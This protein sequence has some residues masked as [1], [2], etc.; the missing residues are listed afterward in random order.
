[1]EQETLPQNK[2]ELKELIIKIVEEI[3]ESRIPTLSDDE[4]EELN[5]FHGES[6]NKQ[7]KK[8]DFESL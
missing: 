6:L 2:S 7:I 4:Q 8:E 3:D 1:M 5:R